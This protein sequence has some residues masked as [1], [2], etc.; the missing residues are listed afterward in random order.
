LTLLKIPPRPRWN[1]TGGE[2]TT[3]GCDCHRNCDRTAGDPCPLK[4]L[5]Y[6]AYDVGHLWDAHAAKA[7]V[8]LWEQAGFDPLWDRYETLGLLINK[9]VGREIQRQEHRHGSHLS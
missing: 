5:A 8:D 1:G 6:L 3:A 4:V 2:D 9:V 7:V